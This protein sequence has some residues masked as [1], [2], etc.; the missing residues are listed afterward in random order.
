MCC[1]GSAGDAGT[2]AARGAQQL[3]STGAGPPRSARLG[4]YADASAPT[5]TRDAA[6]PGPYDLITGPGRFPAPLPLWRSAAYP[7]GLRDRLSQLLGYLPEEE[8]HFDGEQ[9]GIVQS[10]QRAAWEALYDPV[11]GVSA[12]RGGTEAAAE[13]RQRLDNEVQRAMVEE[14]SASLGRRRRQLQ[15]EQLL[16]QQAR[17]EE[18]QESLLLGQSMQHHYRAELQAMGARCRQLEGTTQPAAGYREGGCAAR[19]VRRHGDSGGTP[20]EAGA[21]QQ[22]LQGVQVIQVRGRRSVEGSGWEEEDSR[23]LHDRLWFNS[24]E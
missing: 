23:R 9:L 21:E 19:S 16:E 13:R 12:V 1:G 20:W 10:A 11:C 6:H 2:Q 15:R 24:W 22:G 3:R 4:P 5:A 18:L 8:G 7:G 14:E 17:A